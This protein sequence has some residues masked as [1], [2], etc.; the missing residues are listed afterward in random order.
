MHRGPG[1]E[2]VAA[3]TICRDNLVSGFI[4]AMTSTIWKR[5]WR[6]LMIAFW[7][8][9]ITIGMAP[10]FAYAAPV[11]KFSAPRPSV[12]MQTPGL[13][14]E[15]PVGR[16]HEGRSLFVPGQDELD[17]RSCAAIRQRRGFSSPG[18][19]KIRSTPLVFQCCYQQDQSPWSF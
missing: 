9:S 18:T 10:R 6:L 5:A 16:G 11:K 13:A 17:L 15:A 12:E 2:C 8:V 4:E 14:G 1:W 7:P 19:P 3:L